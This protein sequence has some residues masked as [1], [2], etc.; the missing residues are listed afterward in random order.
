MIVWSLG[1]DRKLFD[2]TTP[3]RVRQQAYAKELGE[4]H[5]IV[6]SCGREREVHEGALH[7]YSTHSMSRFAYWRG[8][9]HVARRL[10][11]PAVITVQDPFETGLAGLFLSW[12]LQ[13]PLHVQV[14][15]DPFAK[16]F[17]RSSLFNR[18]RAIVARFVLA[19]SSSVR[20]VSEKVSE[21]VQKK[22][23]AP[24]TVL[25]IYIDTEK[26]EKL[27]RTKHPRFKIAFLCVG[28]LEREKRFEKAIDALVLVRSKN[29][30]AGLTIVGSG[31]EE[32]KL[33]EYVTS[34]KMDAYVV[35]AGWRDDVSEY[36][37]QADALLMPSD[38][39]G[40]GMVIVEA[41][42]S[43]VPVIAQDV[44]IAREAGALISRGDFADTVLMWVE[45]GA[46][47]GM[48]AL[49]LPRAFDEYVRMWVNN[50]QACVVVKKN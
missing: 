18:I 36:L 30:D 24:I 42:A 44:G 41:L 12:K 20:V 1:T 19:R 32:K 40:Y 5:V 38:Y 7:V 49:V 31:S 43:G 4:L 46:R 14:H 13:V 29:H 9:I 22:T 23:Y 15:T 26:F 48:L 33:R 17:K 11:P 16:E 3:V 8:I 50:I 37:S 6:G 21:S 47:Q 2:E 39:E 45:K 35:F 34:K 10:P 27:P 25:P 28:R